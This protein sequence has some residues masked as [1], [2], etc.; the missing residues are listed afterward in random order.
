MK[1]EDSWDAWGQHPMISNSENVFFIVTIYIV[2]TNPL[3]FKLQIQQ[4][5]MECAK[6]RTRGFYTAHGLTGDGGL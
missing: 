1:S 2:Y 5:T 4:A 3:S 6:H